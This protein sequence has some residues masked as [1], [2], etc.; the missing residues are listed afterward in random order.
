MHELPGV[1]AELGV[2]Q[3]ALRIGGLRR[4]QLDRAVF[5]HFL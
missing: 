2:L 4:H 3:I 1:D 5:Q